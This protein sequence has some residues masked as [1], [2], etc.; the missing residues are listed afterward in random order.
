MRNQENIK[1][2]LHMKIIAGQFIFLVLALIVIYL[3]YPKIEISVNGNTI[4]FDSINGNVIISKNPDFSNPQHIDFLYKKNILLNLEPGTYYWKP[5][6]SLISGLKQEFIVNSEVSLL[7]NNSDNESNL[8]NVGNVKINVTKD[9]NGRIVGYM[10]L[11]PNESK[12]I[13]NETYTGE[14]E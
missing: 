5:Y 10:T 1:R 9:E 8:V 11:E 3:I 14:Q 13:E 7:V 12:E 4:N 2:N 6:N